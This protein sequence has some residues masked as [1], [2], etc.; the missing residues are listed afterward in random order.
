VEHTDAVRFHHGAY[1]RQESIELASDYVV[2]FAG[3][4]FNSGPI[5]D[6]NVAAA[7]L[8]QVRVEEPANSLC[9]ASAAHT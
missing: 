1:A 8:D 4:R 9:H 6:P 5:H 2:A 3:P 7:V